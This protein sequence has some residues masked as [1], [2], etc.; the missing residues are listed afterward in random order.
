MKHIIFL[1]AISLL[2][3][4][5]TTK[6]VVKSSSEATTQTR[7]Q[8]QAPQIIYKAKGDYSQLVPVQMNT[9]KTKIVGF[10]APSDLKSNGGLQTPIALEDGYYYDRRGI[11]KNSVFLNKS[12][13]EYAALVK[14][15][16]IS[17]LKAW[18][19]EKD[20]FLEIYSCP[21]LTAGSDLE[22][23]NALVESGFKNCNKIK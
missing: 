14:T 1:L 15:P 18:I 17:D 9:E 4:C 7:V 16:S 5:S 8:A 3:S 12:Y 19:L 20:P 13:S 23:M 11:S 22:T 2:W 6:E 10:P 21:N